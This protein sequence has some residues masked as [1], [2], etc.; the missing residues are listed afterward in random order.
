MKTK[1]LT[2]LLLLT[3]SFSGLAFAGNGDYGAGNGGDVVVSEDGK[4]KFLD[5][6]ER[7]DEFEHVYISPKSVEHW[8]PVGDMEFARVHI[9]TTL[10]VLLDSDGQ[11][12]P[13]YKNS[14][15]S[16]INGYWFT[17]INTSLGSY[18]RKTNMRLALKP[19]VWILMKET[20][21]SIDDEGVVKDLI[22]FNGK[23]CT[24]CCSK[25]WNCCN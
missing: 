19:L 13:A 24:T 7:H 18:H 16:D 9:E 17:K 14:R 5:L 10:K 2:P 12:C 15:N 3:L 20:I 1:F 25:R 22:N 4:I 21:E 8:E 6:I 11:T 23:S